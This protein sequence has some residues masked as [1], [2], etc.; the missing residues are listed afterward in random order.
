M[1]LPAITLAAALLNPSVLAAA[2]AVSFLGAS[3]TA[4]DATAADTGSLNQI[5]LSFKAF[6]LNYD[7]ALMGAH[8]AHCK[9]LFQSAAT[10]GFATRIKSADV[11]FAAATGEPFSAELSMAVFDS[12]TVKRSAPKAIASSELPATVTLSVGGTSLATPCSMNPSEQ[13]SPVAEIHELTVALI[14]GENGEKAPGTMAITGI[15][16]IVTEAIPCAPSQ[17]EVAR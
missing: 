10:P 6:T 7:P 13:Q 14:A 9:V 8:T 2:E 4:D 17:K 16:N 15:Q 11:T 12:R 3:C 1:I 5:K